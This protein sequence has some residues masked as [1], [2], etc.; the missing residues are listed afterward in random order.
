MVTSNKHKDPILAVIVT[1][2]ALIIG[3]AVGTTA[4]QT[5]AIVALLVIVLLVIIG[6][7]FYTLRQNRKEVRLIESLK[8]DVQRLEQELRN[9]NVTTIGKGD[10]ANLLREW[11]ES[12]KGE[13]LLFN[14]ELQTFQQDM[15][16]DTW[17][18]IDSE[19]SNFKR[20]VLLLPPAKVRRWER[21]VIREEDNFFK[22]PERR[23]FD[24]AQIK[25][26]VSHSPTIAFALYRFS[27]EDGRIC[28]HDSM[29]FFVLSPPFSLSRSSEIPGEDPWWDY[30]SIIKLRR[31]GQTADI[32]GR[33][34]T[35]W[36]KYISD[37]RDVDRVLVDC[38][39]L[40]R[41]EPE[42][43]LDQIN[44][45]PNL[46]SDLLQ[47]LE[48][49]SVEETIPPRLIPA[50]GDTLE[51]QLRYPNCRGAVNGQC[52]GLDDSGEKP[53]LIC[54]GG[55][56]ERQQSSLIDLFARRLD[57]KSVVTL[58]YEVSPPTE[59]VN[60]TRYSEDMRSVWRYALSHSGIKREVILVARS[61][62]GLLAAI[63]AAEREFIDTVL[64]VVLVSPV[65]DIIEMTTR[66]RQNSPEKSS[67]GTIDKLWRYSPGYTWDVWCDKALRLLEFYDVDISLALYLDI[68]RNDPAMYTIEGLKAA[69]GTLTQNCKHVFILS[70]PDDPITGSESAWQ[71][72]KNASSGGGVI[73][74]DYLHLIE[75]ETSHL[76]RQFIT[77]DKS[78]F[79]G[80]MASTEGAVREI[81]E[82]LGLKAE[83]RRRASSKID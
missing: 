49:V 62:N 60:L 41:L 64:G 73:V 13:V 32:S 14:I 5:T 61:I 47:Q 54:V 3:A 22:D 80:E 28:I 43:V 29:L 34:E 74:P 36:N 4:D 75:T 27:D 63:I 20:V 19:L 65:F 71:S 52:R 6:F 45:P 53:A 59:H 33:L 26:E 9:P 77:K 17:G 72:L 25:Q 18:G 8:R 2:G 44:A 82:H 12:G 66:Y 83:R 11:N 78:P 16:F 67:H 1:L 79:R 51:F 23:K 81:L 40:H 68:I 39:T 55:F 37:T 56:T 21:I 48:P 42:F 69:I 31:R 50:G 58:Q 7:V 70:H 46:R 38:K 24:V 30:D 10:Y 35:K 15:I 57:F 76:P